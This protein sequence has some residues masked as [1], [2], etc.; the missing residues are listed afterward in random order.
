MKGIVLGAGLILLSLTLLS[1][2]FVLSEADTK[3][4]AELSR[5]HV[6]DRINDEI[7]A[8]ENGYAEILGKVIQITKSNNTVTFNESLPNGDSAGFVANVNNFK[9][10]AENH[11]KFKTIITL[12]AVTTDLPLTVR[13]AH[14]LYS[15]PRGFGNDRIE[16]TNAQKVLRYSIDILVNRTGA[17]P[18][19][20][21]EG[22]EV[23]ANGVGFSIVVRGLTGTDFTYSDNLSRTEKSRLEI[24]I[25]GADPVIEIGGEDDTGMLR[26]TN[27]NPAVLFVTT[28]MTMNT[29]ELVSVHFPEKSINITASEYN[30]SRVEAI[31]VG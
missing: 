20:W 10:F 26:I 8:T 23:D 29:T 31:R 1:M 13:P 25:P 9:V 11:S 24:K 15:H 2:V 16:V 30:I 19:E 6:F 17:N 3:L 18:V 12:G 4:S 5:R 28:N 22:P 7:K 14:V 21:D 27:G